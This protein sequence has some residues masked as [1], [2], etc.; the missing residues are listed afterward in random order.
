MSLLRLKDHEIAVR[1]VHR[2]ILSKPLILFELECYGPPT[3]M[4]ICNGQSAYAVLHQAAKHNNAL[5]INHVLEQRIPCLYKDCQGSTALDFACKHGSSQAIKTLVKYGVDLSS[6]YSLIQYPH[7][8]RNEL[9]SDNLFDG[10][11]MGLFFIESS[12]QK[13]LPT[14]MIQIIGNKYIDLFHEQMKEKLDDVEGQLWSCSAVKGK[15]LMGV[16]FLDSKEEKI[17]KSNQLYLE[18]KR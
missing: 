5:P 16:L 4:H 3:Q 13:A 6:S 18:H 2:Y 7:K 8:L 1:M 9:A 10:T 14:D 11:T 15:D 12:M 17:K